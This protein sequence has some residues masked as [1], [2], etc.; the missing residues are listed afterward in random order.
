MKRLF[1]VLSLSLLLFI[2]SFSTVYGWGDT[3][4]TPPVFSLSSGEQTS[5][6]VTIFDGTCHVVSVLVIT[7]GTDDAKLILRAG[8][9]S[10]TVQYETTVIGADHYGGRV[11]T[12][13]V[14]F[15]TDCH[16]TLVGAGASYI[17]E[18][19]K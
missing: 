19:I 3:P 5:A 13:P 12:F 6:T 2:G 14:Q 18:Y 16:G 9:G 10:G 7:N 11:W 15:L 17:V 4:G 8:T 1:I